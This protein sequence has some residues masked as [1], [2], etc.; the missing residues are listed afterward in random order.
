MPAEGEAPW[1]LRVLLTRVA[2]AAAAAMVVLRCATAGAASPRDEA[3]LLR[4]LLS[5][6]PWGLRALLRLERAH[7]IDAARPGGGGWGAE[8]HGVGHMRH[9]PDLPGVRVTLITRDVETPYSGML[10]GHVAGM[11]TREE[12]HVDL[13]R[14]ARFARARFIH[15]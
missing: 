11:Y 6:Q 4:V 2:P 14:L 12:C 1:L 7:R 3:A 8:T 15:G 5:D 9:L 13:S 10:P